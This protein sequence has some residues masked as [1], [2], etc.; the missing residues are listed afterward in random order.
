MTGIVRNGRAGRAGLSLRLL[1]GL[2]PRPASSTAHDRAHKSEE[3]VRVFGRRH[4]ADLVLYT[5]TRAPMSA[6]VREKEERG[7]GG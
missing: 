1:F 6:H 4:R 5:D 7:G 2:E 3:T